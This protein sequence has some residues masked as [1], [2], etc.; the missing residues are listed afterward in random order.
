[1]NTHNITCSGSAHF[2][3]PFRYPAIMI[4]CLAAGTCK[5]TTDDMNLVL[6][7]KL[8]TFAAEA[9]YYLYTIYYTCIASAPSGSM[10]LAPGTCQLTTDNLSLIL[11]RTL[12][13]LTAVA[14]RIL[15]FRKRITCICC[16][17]ITHIPTMQC[18]Q[19]AFWFLLG[20]G[21][22]R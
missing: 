7:W 6:T 22:L 1:M 20:A 16:Q 2:S 21:Y 12:T 4:T 10:C 8:T 13:T 11:P 5:F 9:Q 17:G 19:G 18:S 3:V 15:T 14:P